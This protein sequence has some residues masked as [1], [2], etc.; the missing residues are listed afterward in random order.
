MFFNLLV[1]EDLSMGE[2]KAYQ[3]HYM[4]PSISVQI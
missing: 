3:N 1:V 4:S 2:A